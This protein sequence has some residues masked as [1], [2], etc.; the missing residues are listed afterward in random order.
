[1]QTSGSLR[2]D[3]AMNAPLCLFAGVHELP[4]PPPPPG[5]ADGAVGFPGVGSGKLTGAGASLGQII[6]V[7]WSPSGL[8]SNMR[9]V[10]TALTG[11]GAIICFGEYIDLRKGGSSTTQVRSFKNWRILWGLG[12]Q[13]P[14]PIAGGQRRAELGEDVEIMDERI[15]TFAWAKEVLPGRALLAYETD[16]KDVVIMAVQFYSRDSAPDEKGWDI[17]EVARFDARGPHVVRAQIPRLQMKDRKLTAS[18]WA[19]S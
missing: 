4:A 3:P 17:R 5:G 15:T 12:A 1:M 6:R 9:P 7:E 11:H 2:P 14:L 8:G 10:L 19:T 13:L 16:D 18:R